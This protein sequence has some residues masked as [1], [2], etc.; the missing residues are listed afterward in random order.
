MLFAMDACWARR[1]RRQPR[2]TTGLPANDW[3]GFQAGWLAGWLTDWPEGKSVGAAAPLL[4]AWTVAIA[5][6]LALALLAS[7]FFHPNMRR[8]QAG[9]TAL[10]KDREERRSRRVLGP[11]FWVQAQSWCCCCPSPLHAHGLAGWHAM[12]LCCKAM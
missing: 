9:Y 10:S 7:S 12:S 1:A 6:T 3:P 5:F 2:L 8:S 11:L 4:Y